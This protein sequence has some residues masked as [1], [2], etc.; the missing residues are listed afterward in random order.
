MGCP[1][2]PP[3][4]P[5]GKCIRAT[6]LDELPQL[7]NVLRGDLDIVGPR[8]ERP[9]FVEELKK[10]IPYYTLRDSGEARP[11]RVGAGHVPLQRDDRGVQ[12]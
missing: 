5:R 8:P 12:G 11:D 7:I 1:E 4:D 3:C 6:R 2:R 10:V 9:E